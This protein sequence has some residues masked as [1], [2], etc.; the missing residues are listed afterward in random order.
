M[1]DKRCFDWKEQRY[2]KIKETQFIGFI[3]NE[4]CF[5]VPSKKIRKNIILHL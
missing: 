2:K 3:K 5:F 4:D 1:D